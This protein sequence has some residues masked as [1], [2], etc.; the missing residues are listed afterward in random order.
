M[1]YSKP[2]IDLVYEIRRRVDVTMK[3]GVKMANPDMLLELA[4][5]YH[6]CKDTITKALIKELLFLAGDN[7]PSYLEDPREISDAPRQ[8]T[9]VYRGQVSLV[10]APIDKS[11]ILPAK[12]ARIYR[13]QV[14]DY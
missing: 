4:N 7:W 10:P 2:M 11:S 9:K 14:V 6:T 1:Q 8:T 5:F 12:P 3:P 13:G